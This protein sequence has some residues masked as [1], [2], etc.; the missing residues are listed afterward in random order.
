MQSGKNDGAP[1]ID[2]IKVCSSTEIVVSF[3]LSEGPEGRLRGP[4]VFHLTFLF[5]DR[6]A[7]PIGALP[8]IS[9]KSQETYGFPKHNDRVKNGWFGRTSGKTIATTENG[10][11]AGCM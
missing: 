1:H 7:N 9:P 10:K 11:P 5:S 4:P 6:H 3:R 8:P 2:E